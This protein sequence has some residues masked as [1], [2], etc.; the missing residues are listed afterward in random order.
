MKPL[1]TVLMR[2]LMAGMLMVTASPAAAQSDY[3]VKPIR[4]ISPFAAGGGNSILA[5]I[6]GIKLTESLGQQVIVDSRPG[7]NT[8]IGT[9][10]LVKAS[11][12]GYT[13]LLV[14]GS[15]VMVP[16]LVP[17]PY[18]PI[19]DFA[20]VATIGKSEMLMVL[21]TAVA[22]NS[23]KEFIALAK[24]KPGH[25]NYATYGSGSASHLAA[26]LFNNLAGT[27][28]QHIPYKGAA[29]AITDLIGGH[30]QLFFSPIASV[31]APIRSDRLKAAAITGET[32]SSSLP[33]VPTFAE[34]GLP[35]FDMNMWYGVL[36]PATTPTVIVDKLAAEIGKI[37]AM[38]ETREKMAAQGVEPFFFRRQQFVALMKR[39]IEKY[40]RVIKA[41][42]IKM[43][44]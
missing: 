10:A 8:I 26:E 24:S 36:A 18:D 7:G 6:I 40:A 25:L 1:C 2:W 3:P 23:L 27:R 43:D 19:R 9:E 31:I 15:H 29:P 12:D 22:A 13:V 21:G 44:L 14:G 5:R 32:R 28:T 20:S 17:T 16:L 30:V 35:E 11:A 41:A 33:Q 42:N 39:D 38:A 34:A 4:L 37:M